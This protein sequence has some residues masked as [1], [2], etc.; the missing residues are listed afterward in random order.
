MSD[1]IDHV[2]GGW[3]IFES[4]QDLNQGIKKS[5]MF[6]LALFLPAIEIISKI[7]KDVDHYP[8]CVEGLANIFNDICYSFQQVSHICQKLP[9][10]TSNSPRYGS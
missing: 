4:L 2:T 9:K 10:L 7:K 3:R 6:F 1:T 5:K 8:T